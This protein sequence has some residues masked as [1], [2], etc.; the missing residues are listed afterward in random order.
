V[1]NPFPAAPLSLGSTTKSNSRAVFGDTSYDLSNRFTVGAG[2]RYFEDDQEFTSGQTQSGSFHSLDPRAYAQYK[3]T[4]YM[5]LYASAAKGFRSGGFN[6]QNEPSFGPENVR[7]YELGT[8]MSLID[9]RL[10]IDSALF[11]SNYTNYQINGLNLEAGQVVPIT[12]N[13]GA[14]KIKGVE[15][16]ATWRAGEGWT[17]GF[18]GDYID[19]YFY[20]VNATSIAPDHLVGDPLDLFPKYE[21]GL[22]VQRDFKWNGL[23]TFARLD[24]SQQGRETYRVRSIG[25][26][27]L[28]ESDV[29]HLL[30][31]SSEVECNAHLSL[32]IFVKNLLNNRGFTDPFSIERDAARTLPRTL[33]IRFH[34]KFD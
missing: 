18:N 1:T 21:Y 9:N 33:G 15:W 20:K 22:S 5:N 26:W 12:S 16:G 31:F 4:D 19:S 34:V 14:A 2:L 30:N 3:L 28:G 11:Y 6:S 17:F 13:A 25:A 32:G 8:K 24:Y 7:T 10:S 29:I 23:P 27:Y